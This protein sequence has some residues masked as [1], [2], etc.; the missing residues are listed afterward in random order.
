MPQTLV[1]EQARP[2]ELAAAFQLIFQ[3]VAPAEQ[4]GRVANALRLIRQGEFDPAAVWVVRRRRQLIGAVVCL[5]AAGASALI[6]PP[7]VR[8][9]NP[10]P[11]IEDLLL[12]SATTWVRN[13]GAKLGQTLLAPDE[14]HLAASL[15]RNGF[16]HV[17]RLW[18]LR[19]GLRLEPQWFALPKNLHFEDYQRCAHEV[20]HQTLLTT[21]EE[22][23]D[24]PEVNGVRE[25]PEILEGH[26]A[27]GNYNPRRWWLVREGDQPVGV[28]LLAE[29]PDWQGWD[30]SYLGVVPQA[31]GRGIGR[32]L[33]RHALRQAHA[34]GAGQLSLAVDSR[35]QL[36]WKL[37]RGLNFEPFD[38][39]EVYL[40]I[41]KQP[42]LGHAAAR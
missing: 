15:E 30:L 6:W 5:P 10:G 7:Q 3:H 25:L 12:Q 29:V 20:F 16:R 4:P 19:H 34:A 11:P 9:G 23:Q 26:R 41:W 22:S 36:A 39:R 8:G 42:T 21:Y 17:T 24:C 1:A 28:L 38:H 37:Y 13:S 2:E 27:Q 35:N 18:Y 14:A 32:A 31:R 33:A 40:A